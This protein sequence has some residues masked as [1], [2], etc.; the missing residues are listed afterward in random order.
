MRVLIIALL[1]AI[2]YAQTG[3]LYSSEGTY[4][5][6]TRADAE[7]KCS[8]VGMSL[9]TV[10]Q[11]FNAVYNEVFADLCYSG[12]FADDYEGSSS[13][14][15]NNEEGSCSGTGFQSWSPANPG[16][17]CC[18]SSLSEVAPTNCASY[19]CLAQGDYISVDDASSVFCAS[20]TCDVDTC[21]QSWVAA[22][23]YIT[24][25]ITF[26]RYVYPNA[27]EANDACAAYHPDL[28]LCTQD[29]VQGASV[30]NSI[31]ASGFWVTSRDENN[32]NSGYGQ[33]WY[34]GEDFANDC[35]GQTG[36]RDW[37]PASGLG[38]AHC[39]VKSYQKSGYRVI[40]GYSSDGEYST[41]GASAYCQNLGYSYDLCSEAQ[42][43]QVVKMTNPN[44]C[45]SGFMS[46]ASGWYQGDVTVQG[47]GTANS[48][49]AW[50]SPIAGAHCCLSSRVVAEAGGPYGI[51]PSS[52][53]YAQSTMSSGAVAAQ[54]CLDAGYG[55]LC[56]IGQQA[57]VEENPSE[58][59]DIACKVG[60]A[61]DGDGYDYGY[62][63]GCGT[64]DTWNNN[65]RPAG[66]PVAHCCAADVPEVSMVEYPYYNGGWNTYTYDVAAGFCTGNYA[67]CTQDQVELIATEGVTFNGVT[68]LEDKI[69]KQGWYLDGSMGWYQGAAGSCGATGS[70]SFGAS[71]A[72]NHCCLGFE[73]DLG[74]TQAPEP[75]DPPKPP[76]F[77]QYPGRYQFTTEDAAKAA[78]Q[79]QNSEYSLCADY[80]MVMAA[81]EGAGLDVSGA[82]I[83]PNFAGV[84]PQFNIGLSVWLDSERQTLGITYGWYSFDGTSGSWKSW[85]PQN[86]DGDWNLGAFCCYADAFVQ[87]PVSTESLSP[88]LDPTVATTMDPTVEP[89]M[90]ITMDPTADPTAATTSI[91]PSETLPSSLAISGDCQ[92]TGFKVEG[93]DTITFCALD[94]FVYLNGRNTCV[95][96]TGAEDVIYNSLTTVW[97]DQWYLAAEPCDRGLTYVEATQ[98]Q[99]WITNEMCNNLEKEI[100]ELETS[101]A[102]YMD[103]WTQS[104]IDLVN[105][106]K[107]QFTPETQQ[108]LD[109]Y[110]D[111][112]RIGQN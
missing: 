55:Q 83:F 54:A 99:L 38:A 3:P 16:A 32:A 45:M 102:D 43:E 103:G 46:D 62:W 37:I 110:L 79:A 104:V 40:N 33:G 57:Y 26:P 96:S 91:D 88:T 63:S 9:C 61:Q 21:C 41:E 19:D 60:W 107:G 76:V 97:N 23:E 15:F 105:D 93:F 87:A 90:E 56:T 53:I 30:T 34:I 78:C 112:L 85:R 5:N 12:W 109:D 111:T 13:G 25:P 73:A 51:I 11:V 64:A 84:E 39:C 8:D 44:I 35:G 69:C 92:D 24:L 27:E 75:T 89:S 50:L 68:Q 74:T 94:G 67:L 28:Q 48:F 108:A 52:G 86:A 7:A 31:C 58:Y 65:W 81:E 82:D 6:P 98:D 29:E 106:N 36:L 22:P 101:T 70:R 72:T 10:G 14:W 1:A 47:C 71:V 66:N 42:L 4:N 18:S 2:S 49:S 100:V 20:G 80:E 59:G 17:H 95:P 77:L